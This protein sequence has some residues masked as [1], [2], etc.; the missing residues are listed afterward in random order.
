[1][2]KILPTVLVHHRKFV[3]WW[4]LC[5][6][7]FA[8][9]CSLFSGAQVNVTA[10]LGIPTGTYT[11]LHDAFAAINTGQHQGNIAI[12]VIS[13]IDEGSTPAVLYSRNADPC[14]Y[15]SVTISPASD[16][17]SIIGAP[18]AGRGVIELNG[19]DFVTINGDNPNTPGT[20]RNLSISNNGASS[21]I[22]GSCVRIATS[23]AVTSA[24]NN[25]ILNCILLGNVSGGNDAGISNAGV[26]ADVSFGIYIGG[27][28][29]ST[30]IS[31]PTAITG[32]L[33]PAP[34]TSE[35]N[36]TI[37][38]NNKI[39]QCGRAICFNAASAAVSNSLT[40][41]QNDIGAAAAL[42]A[43]PF[44]APATTVYKSGIWIAGTNGLAVTQNNIL[45]IISFLKTEIAG[46]ELNANIGSGALNISGN[47]I[48]GIA[49]N[50]VGSTSSATG[51][52][53]NAAG[54]AF[55]ISGNNISEVH[56]LGTTVPA[57]GIRINS[58]GGVATLTLNKISAVN[59]HQN[60]GSA[61]GILLTSAANGALIQNN[62]IANIMN[63]G[64]NNFAPPKGVAGIGLY[65]GNQHRVYHNS[66][67]LYGASPAIGSNIISCLTLGSFAQT[68]VDIRNNIFANKVSGGVADNAHVCVYFPFSASVAYNIQI[69]NNAY[70]SG[71]NVGVSGVAY[72]GNNVYN[73][74]NLYAGATFDPTVSTGVLNW[75]TFSAGLGFPNNDL[76]SFGGTGAVPFV[77]GTD[78]HITP[79]TTPIESG[80]AALGVA[81]D[82]DGDSRD[83]QNPDMGADEFSGT[84][85]DITGPLI[86]YTV[87]NNTCATGS[88]QLIATITDYSGVSGTDLPVLY[89]SL[90]AGVYTPV[91]ATPLGGNQYQFI[92]GGGVI[93]GDVISY[94][95]VAQDVLNNAAVWPSIGASGFSV[96]PPAVSIPPSAPSTYTI[97]SNLAAGT[98]DVGVGQT[99]TSI[100]QAIDAY[101][102]SCP[103]GPI[104]FRLMDAAYP[105]ET[106]PISISNPFA[107]SVNTLTLVPNAGVPVTVTGS[108][109][110][111]IFLLNG[112]DYVTINGL[113]TG[114]S[115]LRLENTHTSGAV[116]WLASKSASDGA[117]HN[118][119][120]QCSLKAGSNSTAP[121]VI[122]SGGGSR[123]LAPALAP[124]SDNSY[125][126]NS[127]YGAIDGIFEYGT[128][129]TP[130]QNITI[131][132][133]SFGS[134]SINA[135]KLGG[136][137]IE[138]RNCNNLTITGNTI[139]GISSSTSTLVGI[140][141]YNLVKNVVISENKISD[142]S[143]S[144]NVAGA[145]GIW[146][147]SSSNTANIMV[148]NNFIW[149]VNA[150][151]SYSLANNSFGIFVAGGAG[152]NIWFN[153]VSMAMNQTEP[154]GVLAAL[155]ISN[156]VTNSNALD[157]RNNIFSNTAT[158]GLRYAVYCNAGP[159][160]FSAIDNN[161]YFTNSN[162]LLNFLTA[163]KVNLFE[164]QSA[165]GKDVHSMV[166]NPGFVSAV[167]LHLAAN[168]P[169]NG[170]AAA[171]P[172]I[173]TDIDGTAR[174]APMDMGADEVDAT[175]CIGAP[176]KGT[177]TATA[178]SLCSPGPVAITVS[179]YAVGD[180]LTYQWQSAP[181]PGGPYTD[182]PGANVPSNYGVP[183]LA[184]TT[185]FRLKMFC[186]LSGQT[187]YSD[188]VTV[189]VNVPVV[190]STSPQ[191]RCGT[192]TVTLA[193]TTATPGATL[194]WYAAATGGTVLAS[195]PSF[196]TPA[197]S[198]TTTYYVGSSMGNNSGTVG[199]V[200][201][202]AHGGSIGTM[203]NPWD[204][205]FD[206]LQPTTLESVDIF[207]MVSGSGGKIYLKDEN[208]ATL[209]TVN[210]TTN[211]SGG[212]APQTIP[213]NFALASGTGY[214]ITC[215]MP[216]GGILRNES[217][218]SYPYSSQGIKIT[219]NNFSSAYYMGYYNWKFTTLCESARTPVTA[220]VTAAPAIT[221]T[222]TASSICAGGT[223]VLAASSA[224]SGYSY[225]WTP[226]NIPGAS[227]GVAPATTTTYTVKG[228]DASGGPNNGCINTKTVTVTVRPIPSAVTVTPNSGSVCSSGPALL[229]TA[230]NGLISNITAFSEKFNN[231]SNNWVAVNNSTG[232]ISANAA[233]TSRP[234]GYN[235]HG[236]TFTSNDATRFYLTNSDAQGS[237][238]VTKTILTSPAIDL[239]GFSNATLS[240]YH[241][242]NY[243]G[244][245]TAVVEVS[246]DGATWNTIPG[247]SYTGSVGTPSNFVNAA[248]NLDAYAGM[249]AI[250]IRFRYEANWDGWWAIDNI[251]I[252][253][254]MANK[255]TWTQN[256]VAPNSIF[257]DAA[258]TLAYVPA[259]PATSVYVLPTVNTVYTLTSSG[260]APSNC[261]TSANATIII[262]PP[263]TVTIVNSGNPVC[264]GT[265]VFFTA[266]VTNAGSNPTYQW[267]VNGANVGTNSPSYSFQPGEGDKVKVVVT[268][269]DGCSSGLPFT[270]NIDTMHVVSNVPVL[271]TISVSPGNEVC[272][273]T[274]VT[275]TATVVNGGSTPVYEWRRNNIIV[276]TNSPTYSYTPAYGNNGDAITCTVT[277]NSSCIAGPNFDKSDQILLTVHDKG[278][279]G[280][281]IGTSIP[282]NTVCTGTQVTVVAT[283]TH[284]G[285]N[286]IYEFFV[287]G[288][289]QSTQSSNNFVFTPNN[290]DRVRVRLTSNYACLNTPSANQATSNTITLVVLDIAPVSVGLDHTNAL[291]SNVPIIFT[292]QPVNEGTLPVYVFY[293]NGSVIQTGA[294][295]S[296][297]LVN[298]SSGDNVQVQLTSSRACITGNPAIS[299]LYN[300]S[301]TPGP[302]VSVSATC[303]SLLA[304]SGQESLLTATATSGGGTI[305]TY[306]WY[307]APST[308]VGTNIPTY[309][310]N[311]PGS[312]YV[313]VTNSNGCSNNNQA[314]PVVITTL[315][316]PLAGGTYHVPGSGCTGFQTI[317]SAVNYINNY[318]VAGAVTFAI[319]PGYTETAPDGG[320][321]ITATGTAA[322]TITFDRDG[323]GANPVITASLQ[324]PSKNNDGIFKILGGDYIR[325]R[326]LTMQENPANNV[327]VPG[328]GNTMTEWGVALLYATP[329]NGP[330]NNLIE[331]N[332]ISLNKNYPNSFG[333]Y[334]NM[335]HDSISVETQAEMTNNS[336][337]NNKIYGNSIS[338]VNVPIFFMGGVGNNT[339][340]G[341]DIGGNSVATGNIL[342]DWGTNVAPNPGNQ[343]FAVPKSLQGIAVINQA[344]VNVS[345]NTV[346]NA[347]GINAGTNGL[348]GIKTDV[349]QM[350]PSASFLNVISN[351][352][353][354]LNSAASA[355]NAPVI[356]IL[357]ANAQNLATL[358]NGGLQVMNNSFST[359]LTAASSA[360]DLVNVLNQMPFGNVSV[361]GNI[362]SGNSTAA[363]TGTFTGILNDAPVQNT[364]HI[365]NN[366]FGN[367]GLNSIDFTAANSGIIRAIYIKQ[368]GPAASVTA[369]GNV[370]SK[371]QHHVAGSGNYLLVDAPVPVASVS[372]SNNSF[373]QVQPNTTGSVK[374]ISATGSAGTK[375]IN[376][377]QFANITATNNLTLVEVLPT[378]TGNAVSNNQI[379]DNNAAG[380]SAAADF[381]AISL[382]AGTGTVSVASNM[383]K[384]VTSSGV[385]ANVSVVLS[386]VNN[387]SIASNQ[388]SGIQ[389]TGNA[390]LLHAINIQAGNADISTNE[391]HDL[392][393]SGSGGVQVNGISV[394]NGNNINLFKNKVNTLSVDNSVSG[395]SSFVNGFKFSGGTQVIAYN[396]FISHLLAPQADGNDVVRGI[397]ISASGA[398]TN[399]RLYFNSVYLDA[400]STGTNF[401][402]SAV[403]HAASSSPT[404]AALDIRNNI[405]D[406][407]SVASGA[408]LTVAYRRSS[409]DM[410]N[411]ALS[412][413][414]NSFYAGQTA[415]PGALYFNG[416]ISYTT[417]AAMQTAIAPLEGNSVHAKPVFISNVDLHLDVNGNCAFEG[418]GVPVTGIVDDID[419]DVRNTSTPDI[420]ADEF[421]GL[422]G[423][424]GVWAGVNNNWLDPANWCGSIPTNVTDVVI[425]GGKPFYPVITSATPVSRNILVQTGG[426]IQ[427]TGLGQLT[428]YGTLNNAGTVD[429]L[430]G[431]IQ[432]SGSSAQH[433]PSGFFV[434]D[435]LKNLIIDNASVLLDG[436][437]RLYG[438][439]S[440]LGSNRTFATNDNLVLR[441][442]ATGTASLGDI[443]NNGTS[444][445]NSVTG[446]VSVERFV[447]AKRAW[448]F[449]SVP[450]QHNLQTIHEAW[451]EGLPANSTTPSTPPGYGIHITKDSLNWSAYG[452][453]LHTPIGPS[454]KTYVPATN[455]WKGV[456]STIDI[457][458]V[459]NGR[460]ET[461]VGYMVIVRGDRTVNTFPQAATTVTLRDKG[462]L[463]QGNFV[464]IPVPNGLFQAIGNPYASAVDFSKLTL[465]NLDD[466]YYMW[467]P[468]MGTLGAYVTFTGSAYNPSPSVSYTTNH[469]IESGQAFFVHSNGSG[470]GGVTFTEPSK[471]D[472]SYLVTRQ[473]NAGLGKLKTM[474]YATADNQWNLFDGTVHEFSPEYT[475]EVNAMDAIKPLNSG[476]NLGIKVGNSLLSVERHAA[477]SEND[478]LYFNLT[479]MR[480]TGYRFGFVP[481]NMDPAL[482]GYLIDQYLHTSTK[483]SMLDTTLIDFS[484]INNPES[485]SPDRFY[486]V[487]KRSVPVPV[488]FVDVKAEWRNNDVLVS[489]DV[490]NE[491]NIHHYEVERSANGSSFNKQHE[492][493][494]T[495]STAYHWLDTHPLAGDNF[496]RISSIGSGGDIKYSQ[497]VKVSRNK[498]ASFLTIFPNPVKEDGLIYVDLENTAAGTYQLQ[499]LNETGQW[500][501][502]QSIFHAGGSSVYAIQLKQLVAHGNYLLKIV[503]GDK[504]IKQFKL[505]Y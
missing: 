347:S 465:T 32:A 416:A 160:V 462:A 382:L 191:S 373:N 85:S 388:I 140:G 420:G 307:L 496:Y 267:Q 94:Y 367:A 250:Y 43:F 254:S 187:N 289:L 458:G 231:T 159:G 2:E 339:P 56:N 489:W 59:N 39:V 332:I 170:M 245:E 375:N 65:S 234:N 396:N 297:T 284:P 153:S 103:Q 184:V 54:G 262:T 279:V 498:A 154:M 461:G 177:T 440:F 106:F 12:A 111:A 456:T 372:I 190:S 178:T 102:N 294:S 275:F 189:T 400:S 488:T 497:I 97:Q 71:N 69:N 164:W 112:A 57:S 490:A 272:E 77:S 36:N 296:Y 21:D 75:R 499:L 470:V 252:T 449:L 368:A 392:H 324:F 51:V 412:S 478:T 500:V 333:I 436:N 3:F 340:L 16:N 293:L 221:A 101:N 52:L 209:L 244:G 17:I 148:S 232:G 161:L 355:S 309:T 320:F 406:N 438:K 280:V 88:R 437:L 202:T 303:T 117:T 268:S 460:F 292:A 109:A 413:N 453:D 6:T 363:T 346:T 265:N 122:F 481:E 152:Y 331:N 304:G 357:S 380:I 9:F 455:T 20:N 480:A 33:Q 14:S 10:T 281:T 121:A 238:S 137:G 215:F 503:K 55:T 344:N 1:M 403:Y 323:A 76:S 124:N 81:K 486:L 19:A 261:G 218:S 226:G 133:N 352:S 410:A 119:I 426:S 181:A 424:V 70:F 266:A 92:F 467:D 203:I 192:G 274:T 354:T 376:S 386:L 374:V 504:Q 425:P 257:V 495:G 38:Q 213:I 63:M 408:G 483:V 366:L 445:G 393:S 295:P 41:T 24:N 264:P 165:T 149:A 201:P 468:K 62:F 301:L 58:N 492:E 206:V 428:I 127:I 130:N 158:Q 23:A 447:P 379:G 336:A 444:S 50:S 395:A 84:A 229:L 173:T 80:G 82:I 402:S 29:G 147:Q 193:A 350:A 220:T 126:G 364:L 448:R 34:A 484:I 196:V 28:G 7:V 169:A 115:S 494:A 310:T 299:P 442:V 285:N 308:A 337:G 306:Q 241:H 11:T 35:I 474:L 404:T 42:G 237:G 322:N 113:N 290:G 27:N 415:T 249:S 418:R 171:I 200:S 454:M 211:V 246:P 319:A 419:G 135:D 466:V 271:T 378:G 345:W 72:A 341:N 79:G 277:S 141:L 31:D 475:N 291:C 198:A 48:S 441:S 450:T 248:L 233:W 329:T 314:T 371:F 227:T 316:T 225:I 212:V 150:F 493:A 330:S 90:N 242:L 114:G 157:I 362:F 501:H 195:G 327:M 83:M 451:Q 276:G 258:A 398:N 228:T 259:T 182:I 328:P 207:P 414:N 502:R 60:T 217:G 166:A 405:F 383:I 243:V 224:N 145:Y 98:Y 434:N 179:G 197:I 251:S 421:T 174:V 74:A 430:D 99:Y 89:W 452:F 338:N 283:P 312:Y 64:N 471:V 37:I 5:L 156:A 287:N 394:F 47:V 370:V 73:A 273:N 270:S 146:L 305:D 317:A 13:N 473:A 253:G 61:G 427:I 359:T 325:I 385:G 18:P 163:S 417:L 162:L 91:T 108:S 168:S 256:P 477:L 123:L 100:T 138:I 390:A 139:A 219:G 318:G 321:S 188:V 247:G 335:R 132:S 300:I 15:Q 464:S 399:Y 49:N 432:L 40:I 446:N 44:T 25:S 342:T 422:G 235:Y 423:G 485:Y 411:Y 431:A 8:I 479:Q 87:L 22:G 351:N 288:V 155:R 361:N 407:E 469:Y 45:D 125:S 459:N 186:P 216:S 66:V 443:T 223:S 118:S 95:I 435:D 298:P 110:S 120:L 343:F 104:V 315:T 93:L 30:S 311:V 439:L 134:T 384:G 143:Q 4:R 349:L 360:T 144:T 377:N 433:I 107:S 116:I 208:G 151:G 381:S 302:S 128:A 236:S 358:T 389:T 205:Y 129:G 505:I 204:V 214:V 260:P 240:F 278:N 429:A 46:I 282:N 167:N 255:Y 409:A 472:G 239:T 136:R 26:S 313:V 491:E 86:S 176:A 199:P 369:D 457:P 172:A 286:P 222:A 365:D 401:G 463:V 356:S 96:A 391:I 142:I 482:T 194:K 269:T 397:E 180:Y 353:I 326:N 387:A 68:D 53:V 263:P 348:Y 230:S 175:D 487:F 67:Y 78:L 183:L 105:S 334:S 210:F 131:T 185:S 476:E